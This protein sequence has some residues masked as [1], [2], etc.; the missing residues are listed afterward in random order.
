MHEAGSGEGDLLGPAPG[1]VNLGPL[2][3]L[4][5]ELVE[6]DCAVLLVFREGWGEEGAE[7]MCCEIS[8]LFT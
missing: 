1:T 5:A 8:G 2:E 3:Q 6:L 4:G 7:D